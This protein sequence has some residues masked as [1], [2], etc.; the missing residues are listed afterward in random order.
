MANQSNKGTTMNHLNLTRKRA[1]SYEEIQPLIALCKAGRL[2]DVQ[3][4]IASGRPI[5]PPSELKIR[6]KSPLELAIALGFHSLVEVLLEGGTLVEDQRY[7]PLNHALGKRRLDLIMLLAEIRGGSQIGFDG[8][9]GCDR[10][11]ETDRL[12]HRTGGR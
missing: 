11:P 4:W 5:N 9:G 6:K 8:P 1:A 7:S 12:L 2:F 10:R 3:K